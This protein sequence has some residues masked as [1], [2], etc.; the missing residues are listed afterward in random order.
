MVTEMHVYCTPAQRERWHGGQ[1]IVVMGHNVSSMNRARN[2]RRDRAWRRPSGG[3]RFGTRY[4]DAQNDQEAVSRQ[5]AASQESHVCVRIGSV[6]VRVVRTT[7][8]VTSRQYDHS[9]PAC[10]VQC[11]V[12]GPVSFPQTFPRPAQ[13]GVPWL[14]RFSHVYFNEPARAPHR[15]RDRQPDTTAGHPHRAPG[16]AT[17]PRAGPPRA[18]PFRLADDPQP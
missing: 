6:L 7:R 18:S 3:G 11:S 9:D 2:G 10:S 5:D 1:C 15:E 4:G 14:R 13:A 16:T 17:R 8:L 12:P